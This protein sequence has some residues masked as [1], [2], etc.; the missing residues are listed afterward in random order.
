M[1]VS[2]CPPTDSSDDVAARTRRRDMAAIAVIVALTVVIVL[3]LPKPP[4]HLR[5]ITVDNPTPYR[6]LLSVV[7]SDGSTTPLG[8]VEPARQSTLGDLVDSGANWRVWTSTQGVAA[9][10]FDIDGRDAHDPDWVLVVPSQV[11]DDLA[12]Q[13]A[14]PEPY[15]E[16]RR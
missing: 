16:A 3:A 5:E 9:G 4:S 2:S 13:G 6:L 10:N 12:A 1:T 7:S 15:L 8:L 14:T 11:A